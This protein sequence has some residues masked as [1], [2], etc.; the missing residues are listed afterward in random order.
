[1]SRPTQPRFPTRKV[2]VRLGPAPAIIFLQPNLRVQYLHTR[3]P[4]KPELAPSCHFMFR[5]TLCC[6]TSSSL[7]NIKPGQISSTFTS[8]RDPSPHRLEAGNSQRTTPAVRTM[9]EHSRIQR[10]RELEVLSLCLHFRIDTLNELCFVLSKLPR[11]GLILGF[12]ITPK[13]LPINT[14]DPGLGTRRRQGCGRRQQSSS[15]PCSSCR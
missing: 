3:R 14:A 4:A 13:N 5:S 7:E 9:H 10:S 1:M 2:R 12:V 6:P 11:L 8:S 15:L